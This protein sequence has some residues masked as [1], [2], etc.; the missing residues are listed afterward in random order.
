MRVIARH[1]DTD[2]ATTPQEAGSDSA[3]E[4]APG[5]PPVP[6]PRSDTPQNTHRRTLTVNG[7]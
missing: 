4:A 6:A 3:P 7:W 1:C 2:D 5:Q